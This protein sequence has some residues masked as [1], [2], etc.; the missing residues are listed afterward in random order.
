MDAKNA[1]QK[2]MR[3]VAP[4]M[5]KSAI[6]ATNTSVGITAAPPPTSREVLLAA[7]TPGLLL[8]PNV[9]VVDEG[10]SVAGRYHERDA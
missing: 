9:A 1:P 3:R 5:L 6:E 7:T 4:R 10:T 8:E 2:P